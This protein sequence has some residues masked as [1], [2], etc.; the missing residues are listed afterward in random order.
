MLYPNGSTRRPEVSSPY[1]RRD[2]KIG[3]SSFHAGADLIG[4]DTVH[5]VADGKVTFAGYMNRAAGN[6][7]VID[8]GHGVTTIYMH[9]RAHKV[10]AGKRVTAGQPIAVMGSSGNATGLCSHFEVRVKGRHVDPLAYV[11]STIPTT[12]TTGEEDMLQNIKGKAGKRSGGTW[13]FKDGKATFLGHD[14]KN[15]APYIDSEDV[16]RNLAEHYDGLPA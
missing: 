13:L 14:P 16:I 11:A 10:R 1:G 6:T 9:N 12:T 3:V 15:T 7:I 5:A 8:H 2:P 4:F